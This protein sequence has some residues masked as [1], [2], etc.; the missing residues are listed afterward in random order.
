MSSLRTKMS[1]PPTL[2]VRTSWMRSSSL[3]RVAK[4]EVERRLGLAS[5]PN[6][7][8]ELAELV[9]VI[10]AVAATTAGAGTGAGA[11]AKPAPCSRFV[12][13]R[14][15]ATALRPALHIHLRSPL[16][17]RLAACA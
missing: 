12:H 3:P 11:G 16:N 10:I 14:G 7:K 8:T 17:A 15:L 13:S 1:V 5:R 9:V 2:V 4:K 6:F